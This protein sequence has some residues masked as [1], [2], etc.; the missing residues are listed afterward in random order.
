MTDTLLAQ[1]AET[2]ADTMEDTEVTEQVEVEQATAEV[3]YDFDFSAHDIKTG[4]TIDITKDP[5]YQRMIPV[6]KEMNLTQEQAQAMLSG[7]MNQTYGAVD[8]LVGDDG[9]IFGKYK[10]AVAAQEA[11]KHLESENGRLR[12]ERQPTAPEQYVYDFSGDE[13]VSSILPEDFDFSED[14]LVKHMEPVFKE[15]NF[16]QEQ[17]NAATKAW[18][19]YQASQRVDTKA[20]M[21][22]LG[23]D[24]PIILKDA[25]A[26][27]DM[28]GFSDEER[29]IIESWVTTADE[30]R[31]LSKIKG[32][33]TAQSKIPAADNLQAPTKS[34]AEL[35]AEAS[36]I[37]RK[38]HF[39]RD[40][41]LQAIYE[42]KMD[43]AVMA[44]QK[45]Y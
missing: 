12:R 11:F 38:P 7:Y 1:E 18:L 9:M 42:K 19:Q 14:P 2:S 32:M 29:Q 4:A 16:T 28:K 26:L 8:D 21:E 45:G 25:Q 5:I 27:R 35:Y 22:S 15:A 44:E 20:E 36:E 31:L 43:Q 30:A 23:A 41:D 24:A 17:V 37:R 3:D 40:P 34:S 33:M 39:T 10:D 13:D 6:F